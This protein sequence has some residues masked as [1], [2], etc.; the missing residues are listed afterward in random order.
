MSEP[1]SIFQRVL[2]K[3]FDGQPD[4]ETL[5]LLE[6]IRS[7]SPARCAGRLVVVV[8]EAPGGRPGVTS[9]PERNCRFRPRTGNDVRGRQSVQG[10]VNAISCEPLT[11][12]TASTMYCLPLTT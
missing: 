3:Y 11:P 8:A 2:D 7:V 12:L 10:S 1:G 6:R 4:V 5:R 9:V